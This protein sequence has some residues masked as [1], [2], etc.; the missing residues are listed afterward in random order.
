M[1]PEK[2]NLLIFILFVLFLG[3]QGAMAEGPVPGKVEGQA[4]NVAE[5]T[6]VMRLSPV[7]ISAT[8]VEQS[9][10]DLPV[11][12]DLIERH[13]IQDGQAQVNLSETLARIPGIVVQNRQNYAQDL[14]ISSRGFGSRSAFGVRGIRLLADGV[15]ATMPDGQGQAATFSLSSASRIEVLRGPYSTIYG[16]HSG[17][18]IQIFTEDG[19]ERPT[20]KLTTVFGKHDT[21]RVGIQAGG[22]TG[23]LNYAL[24]LSRFETNGYR[25]HSSARRDHFNGKWK[26]APDGD[27]TLTLVINVFDQPGA[28]DPLGL[29]AAQV[30]SNRRQADVAA[31]QFNT[32]KDIRHEQGGLTYERSFGGNDALR[33]MG[34]YG[35]RQVTQFQSIPTDRQVAP[36][37][38]GG[39]IDFDRD[40]G[41]LGLRWTHQGMLAG[42]P[43]TVTAGIDHDRSDEDR[44]GYQNFVGVRTGVR[45]ALKRN[46]N[47]Q[48]TSLNEYVQAEWQPA[49]RWTLIAGLRHTEVKFKTRDFFLSGANPDDSGNL[50]HRNTS[51]AAGVLFKLTPAINLYTNFG[52][53]FETPTFNELFYKPDGATGLNLALKPSK[54]RSFEAGIKAFAGAHTRVNL[55]LF[56]IKTTNE[57]VVA[58]STGGRTTFKN[59]GKTE[60]QGVELAVDSALGRGLDAYFSATYLDASFED[61]FTT[62]VGAPCSAVTVPSGNRLPG[63][64]R[65]ALYGE[66]AWKHT[67]S[68]FSTALEARYNDKTHVHDLNIDAPAG[69]YSVV[70]WRVG[71]EQ[72][73]GAWRF[74]EF[75]RIDNLFDRKYIG[76]VIVGDTNKRYYEPAPE[77]NFML[78][79]NVARSF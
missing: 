1:P 52:K 34:Y 49:P 36:T 28:Q 57:I 61:A 20:A 73:P 72:N 24:D 13:T 6:G 17:G 25:D 37:H 10:F 65:R 29:T 63:V 64:P 21:S 32:R 47:D 38:P 75:L 22:Q 4:Q 79:V 30:R 46:E 19:P 42:A 12:I 67:P 5:E 62:C 58:S 18:V 14:Q 69:G 53:G 48:V 27:S 16:N 51:P 54:S 55:A 9:S 56:R 15:P 8:R 68:G 50:T 41:G 77:R 31:I 43:L 60:R 35:T 66:I 59:A 76:S 7:V 71:F 23:G 40:F 39:V 74:S 11:S 78:G 26:Y 45:G 70:N 3:M 2:L 33:V 44:K